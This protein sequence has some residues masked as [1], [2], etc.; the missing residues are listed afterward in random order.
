MA[1]TRTIIA[2][3]S[4]VAVYS[5]AVVDGD[6]VYVSGQVALCD[7]GTKSLVG[8]ADVGLQAAQCLSNL[9]AVLTRAGS[10]LGQA[11]MVTIYLTDMSS[12]GAFNAVYAA[13]LESAGITAPPA[14]ACFAVEALPLGALVEVEA[15]AVLDGAPRRVVAG[16]ALFSAAVIAGKASTVYVAGQVPIDPASGTL[17][18]VGGDDVQLQA[19][20]SLANV[21]AVLEK[22]G[23]SLDLVNKATVYLADMGGY[24]PM[25]ESYAAAFAGHMPAR[26]AFAVKALPLGAA[27]EICCIASSSDASAANVGRAMVGSAAANKAAAVA[28]VYSPAVIAG[29]AGETLYSAGQIALDKDLIAAEGRKVLVGAGDVAKETE[30]ALVNMRDLL[31]ANGAS[32]KEALKVNIFIMDMGKYADVNAV[33]KE[34]FGTVD[35]PARACVQVRGLPMGS[36]VEIECVAPRRA[37]P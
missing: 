32:I 26:S 13:A 33:Y 29:Y 16:K 34:F 21:R 17:D 22:A 1:S 4:A 35:P 20:Q 37:A 8:G 6:T 14:R 19:A 5:P 30:R 15:I 18:L 2:G 36:Q 7:D 9:S 23:S 10:S 28:P 25:N 31:A 24:T 12:Y 11:C 3:H 27:V